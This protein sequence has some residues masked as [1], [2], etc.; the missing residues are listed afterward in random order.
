MK[1]V[2]VLEP[3]PFFRFGNVISIALSR[4]ENY[5]LSLLFWFTYVRWLPL[6]TFRIFDINRLFGDG[7]ANIYSR[8]VQQRAIFYTVRKWNQ[9]Y[10]MRIHDRLTCALRNVRKGQRVYSRWNVLGNALNLN[11]PKSFI[12]SC[13]RRVPFVSRSIIYE[14]AEKASSKLT[15]NSCFQKCRD[16][17]PSILET[18][19]LY[20]PL[21]RVSFTVSLS[22]YNFNRSFGPFSFEIMLSLI[23]SIVQNL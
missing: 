5:F 9:A 13:E 3:L 11:P 16:R 22:P 18:L 12:E 8:N 21:Y 10:E 7:M 17:F 1:I 15:R 14:E 4:P 19:V 6:L 23:V 2:K 20:L